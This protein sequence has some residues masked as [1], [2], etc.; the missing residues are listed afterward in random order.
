MSEIRAAIDGT[1][2]SKVS[3]ANPAFRFPISPLLA[4]TEELGEGRG[5]RENYSCS[6]GF[7]IPLPAFPGWNPGMC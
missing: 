4:V 7:L 5:R 2:R 1:R 6:V 3:E